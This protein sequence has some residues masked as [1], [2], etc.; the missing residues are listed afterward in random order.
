MRR[1]LTRSAGKRSTPLT[2][3]IACLLAT[4]L[5]AA[6]C[7]S[8][9][10]HP[11][12][13]RA[14]GNTAANAQVVLP[15][16]RLIGAGLAADTAIAPSLH[17]SVATGVRPP[18]V[19][20]SAGSQIF[21]V[22][23]DREPASPA[24]VLLPLTRPL[25]AK[26]APLIL[27]ASSQAGPWQPLPTHSVNRGRQAVADTPHFSLFT[28]LKV[29]IAKLLSAAKDL[30]DETTAGVLANAKPPTCQ[31]EAD[32]RTNGWGVGWNGP[33][34]LKWCFGLDSAGRHLLTVVN[35]RRYPLDV[36]YP[37]ATLLT[38]GGLD[39]LELSTFARY[40]TA[41]N[42]VLLLPASSATFQ[43]TRST[44][45]RTAFDGLAESVYALQTG[46]ELAISF[47]TKFGLGKGITVNKVYDALHSST[48]C[49]AALAQLDEGGTVIRQCF[50][51]PKLLYDAFGP[52]G[53]AIGLIIAG[54][55]VVEFFHSEFNGLGDQ[56]NSRDRYV[57]YVQYKP[58]P[59]PAGPP[60]IAA[61][62]TPPPTGGST[63][64]VQQ[65]A[66]DGQYAISAGSISLEGDQSEW[67]VGV[68]HVQ[69]QQ[70][71]QYGGY[72]D[73]SCLAATSKDQCPFPPAAGYAPP[74]SIIIQLA[75]RAGLTIDAA[76]DVYHR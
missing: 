44:S 11:E 72:D 66:C 54:A 15:G 69:G 45:V 18:A 60:C 74:R 43:M 68:W 10:R 64:T 36:S 52:V 28:T 62:L 75:L 21:S 42:T 1:D 57:V 31:R 24:R 14:T 2:T 63:V 5:M 40:A 39:P 49:T 6:G 8:A 53:A 33:D 48:A 51:D 35:N 12:I 30:L 47:L 3:L 34:T 59:A 46:V 38:G 19:G 37:G 67:G 7:T 9:R 50:S 56:F 4:L 61:A 58:P 27:V 29:D 13:T 65:F 73:G 41:P 71:V 26:E 22:H 70:W 55:G 76:G 20:L 23:A 16:M 25:T 17:A 32:A